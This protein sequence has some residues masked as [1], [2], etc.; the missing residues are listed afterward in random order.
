MSWESLKE[1]KKYL[2]AA[3][4]GSFIVCA[5]WWKYEIGVFVTGSVNG[6]EL[7]TYSITMYVIASGFAVIANCSFHIHKLGNI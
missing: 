7:A 6:V 4:P 2:L 1:W 5:E 3:I